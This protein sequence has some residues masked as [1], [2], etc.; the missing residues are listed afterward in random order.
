MS[1]TSV[2][3]TGASS[4]IGAALARTYAVSGCRLV[5]WGRDEARL[6]AIA[7][8]CRARGAS[9]ETACF[10]LTDFAALAE[11]LVA[12]D[13][14]QALDL[15]IF[16][17]GLGGSLPNDQVAQDVGAAQRLANVNFTVPVI[18]ANLLAQRMAGRG[19]GQIVL[20][21]SIAESFPLPMAPLYA[22]TKAGLALFAEAFGLRLARYGIAVTLISPGFVDTPMSR[23]LDEPKPFLID[24][25]KAAAIIARKIAR[26]ARHVVLPW[27]FAVI[28]ALA[29]L[30]PRSILRAVLSRLSRLQSAR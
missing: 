27:Q 7:E 20:V 15:A 17:A 18:G 14:R 30:V 13:S 9:I 19:G 1:A 16:N 8:Q 29:R 6:A 21:G 5:L 10:D 12:A 3:I 28:G 23:S 4:G 2:L 22:G 26:R 25:D 11:H 24:A